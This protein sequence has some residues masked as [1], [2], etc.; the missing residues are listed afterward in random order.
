MKEPKI[1]IRTYAVEEPLH[2]W[3]KEKAERE[4]R[5]VIKQ[6][7]VILEEARERDMKGQTHDR[8]K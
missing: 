2:E 3:L 4:R 1:I 6:V 8:R 5:P 7:E